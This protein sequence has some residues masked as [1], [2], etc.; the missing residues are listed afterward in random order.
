MDLLPLFLFGLGY[1]GVSPVLYPFRVFTGYGHLAKLD[2]SDRTQAV[3]IAI[4]YGLD[5]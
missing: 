4:R 5:K 3:I 2:V 1:L